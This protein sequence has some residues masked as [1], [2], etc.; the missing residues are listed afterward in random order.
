MLKIV[1]GGLIGFTLVLAAGLCF[2][3]VPEWVGAG[4]KAHPVQAGLTLMFVS[5]CSG[6]MAFSE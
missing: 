2:G 5:L 4:A 3:H 1:A 6:F